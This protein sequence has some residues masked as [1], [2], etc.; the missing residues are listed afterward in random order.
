MLTAL[1]LAG[2]EGKRLFPLSTKD[3][4]KQFLNLTGKE[5]MLTVTFKRLERILPKERIFIVTG[6]EYKETV[7]K[8]IPYIKEENIIVEPCRKNTAACTMLSSLII[9]EKIKNSMMLVVPSDHYI[10][11]EMKFTWAVA[12]GE[13]FLA[14]NISSIITMGIKPTRAETGYGYLKIDKPVDDEVIQ[15]ERFVEKP[16]V[17]KAKEFLRSEKYLW[18]SGIFMWNTESFLKIAAKEMKETYMLIQKFLNGDH[19]VYELLDSISL[20]YGIMEKTKDIYV[21]PVDFK[22]DDMGSYEAIDRLEN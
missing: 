5:S 15:V 14:K 1:I 20:D 19:K 3:K 2:G 22:W 12:Q 8:H 16:S 21:I 9:K 7:K 11:N 6:E 17:F 10:E 4:P 18:N 13:R